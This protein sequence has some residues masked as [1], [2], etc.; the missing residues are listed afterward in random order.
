M[1][2]QRTQCNRKKPIDNDNNNKINFIRWYDKKI[3]KIVEKKY[4]RN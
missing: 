1:R 2:T 3:N 4:Q